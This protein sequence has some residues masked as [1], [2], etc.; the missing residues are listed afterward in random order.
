VY[1]ASDGTLLFSWRGLSHAPLSAAVYLPQQQMLITASTDPQ[2]AVSNSGTALQAVCS[3]Q[4]S[5]LCSSFLSRAVALGCI[6]R[7]EVQHYACGG[8]LRVLG[9]DQMFLQA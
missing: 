2:L 3:H 4:H 8:V 9:G 1:Q 5:V 6:S 7:R